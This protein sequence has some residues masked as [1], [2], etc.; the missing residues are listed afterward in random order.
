MLGLMLALAQLHKEA[1]P[2]LDA[3]RRVAA[4]R[5]SRLSGSFVDAQSRP[6]QPSESQVNRAE[7]GVVPPVKGWAEKGPRFETALD[8]VLASVARGCCRD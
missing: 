3:A 8:R 4:C 1:H 6:S 7:S 5:G 2:L